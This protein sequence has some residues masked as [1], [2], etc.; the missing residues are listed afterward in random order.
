[1]PD[2]GSGEACDDLDAEICRGTG[3]FLHLLDRPFAFCVC[4]SGESGGSE[5]VGSGIIIGIAGQLTREVIADRPDF[6]FVF[7]QGIKKFFAVFFVCRRLVD[8]EVVA[9]SGEFESLI[10]PGGSFSR[11]CF[12]RKIR[13]LS[14]KES[15]WSHS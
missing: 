11:H 2:R 14:S 12:Q 15:D 6:E 4:F 13:P 5:T 1:M 7:L 3:A 9:G 10:S 8:I